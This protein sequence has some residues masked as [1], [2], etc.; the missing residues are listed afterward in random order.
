MI[1]LYGVVVTSPAANTTWYRGLS[2]SVW[3]RFRLDSSRSNGL[4]K[5]RCLAPSRFEQRSQR[6]QQGVTH[7]FKRS[8]YFRPQTRWP[9]PID[10]GCPGRFDDGDVL[11]KSWPFSPIR[12]PHRNVSTKLNE[13]FFTCSTDYRQGLSRASYRITT[14]NH[15][16]FLPLNNG[17]STVCGSKRHLASVFLFTWYVHFFQLHQVA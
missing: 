2:V 12:H 14:T 8:V 13:R 9:S 7:R 15:R 4:F 11:A 3:W 6:R 17:R 10:F 16:G 1:C 5:N